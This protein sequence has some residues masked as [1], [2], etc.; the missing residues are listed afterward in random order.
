MPLEQFDTLRA[1][2]RACKML[3]SLFI[4]ISGS[5]DDPKETK[6]D[7]SCI[8]NKLWT[9]YIKNLCWGPLLLF[10]VLVSFLHFTMSLLIL[11]SNLGAQMYWA[12]V[13]VLT[14]V[15]VRHLIH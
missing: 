12:V 14:V 2:V 3:N 5:H 15:Q 10:G 1:D 13:K 6:M 8:A 7:P 11:R 4:R 9:C